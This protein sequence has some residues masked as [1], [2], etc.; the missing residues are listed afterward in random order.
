[1]SHQ[2]ETS[3]V[4]LAYNGLDE[5]TRPCI[6]SILR[7]TQPGSYELVLVDNASS[8]GT[9]AYFEDLSAQHDHVTLCLNKKNKGYAGGN[10]DGMRLAKGEYVVLLNND[11]LVPPAWLDRLLSLLKSNENV[12]LAGPVT[13]SAGNEQRIEITGLDE[14]N[15][16]AFAAPYL[17]R[18]QG[19]WFT[20]E[21]LGFYCVALKRSV[22]E[23]VGFLDERFGLGM[24]EDDDYCIRVRKSGFALA[25]IEDC[26]VYHKGSVSFGKL[27]VNTYRELFERN[28]ALFTK[29]HGV[30]W[31]FS[32]IALGYWEK[33]NKDLSAYRQTVA[34]EKID[35]AIE[36]LLI[37]WENYHHL[38]VQVHRAEL[39]GLPTSSRDSPAVKRAKWRIR[40]LN[41]RR[42]VVRG[43]WRERRQYVA[44]LGNRILHRFL[45][46]SCPNGLHPEAQ[47]LVDALPAPSDDQQVIIFPATIDYSYMTQRP[48][49]LANAFADAGYFV[50][51]GTLN[52]VSDTVDVAQQVRESVY[53]VNERYFPHI[54]H[55]VRQEKSIYYCMWPNNVK[56]LEYLP[57]SRLLYDYM[58]ELS[59]LDLPEEQLARDHQTLLEKAALVTVSADRLL[60]NLPKYIL[61][62]TLLINNAVSDD[63]VRAVDNY[64]G[65]PD[66]LKDCDGYKVIGYY[67]AIAEWLDFE[68]IERLA[69]EMHNAKIVLVGP[70]NDTVSRRLSSITKNYP[71]ILL[72]PMRKQ[73]D[74]IPLVKR[75][76]VCMIPFIKN[77]VTDAVSPVKLFEYFSAGKPIVT[78]D[79]VECTKYSLVQ[80]GKSHDEFIN[81]T[82]LILSGDT[83]LDKE[84]ARRLAMDNTWSLRVDQIV[85]ALDKQ[86][87]IRPIT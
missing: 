85:D 41:F 78:T 49:Q 50:I 31:S 40:W 75:F 11:T 6:E 66:E 39:A 36:R 42:N 72:L 33:F 82:R 1:M 62:K 25:V 3:I 38:L 16:E 44:H 54:L 46:V 84:K 23:R 81:E 70:V 26:F 15:F 21:R 67:G 77:D 55:L 57:Y 10:N 74:L 63:F 19:Q 43:S 8:D 76:D 20:T 48:Q 65:L 45:P 52:H 68:L 29:L 47:L 13:N 80:I 51:Y 28:R 58:D 71:N 4:V 14:S 17:A 18:Q 27:S 56:H 53:L 24:F 73:L 2:P 79:L 22:I 30:Q 87:G 35:P 34:D 59:L 83:L 7:N 86:S 61:P 37:R 60:G 32:D 64:Q 12:G 9:A 69:I 5:V